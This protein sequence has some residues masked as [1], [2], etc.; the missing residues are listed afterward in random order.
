MRLLQK[1]LLVVG[2]S[3]PVSFV[4]CSDG[5]IPM[6]T[7]DSAKKVQ[8]DMSKMTQMLPTNPADTKPQPAAGGA[9]AEAGK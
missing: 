6:K 8:D 7:D 3:F 4:G 9:P 1:L 2:V 5:G